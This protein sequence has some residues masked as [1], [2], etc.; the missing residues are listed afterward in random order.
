MYALCV[1]VH[2]DE[3]TGN[4]LNL[5]M[6]QAD[7]G[8]MLKVNLPVEFKG[9]AACPGLKKGTASIVSFSDNISWYAQHISLWHANPEMFFFNTETRY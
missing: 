8:T 9:E 4:I 3:T 1:Q 2:R 6:V 7:E 5:V